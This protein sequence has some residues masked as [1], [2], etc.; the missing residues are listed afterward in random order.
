MPILTRNGQPLYG[1]NQGKVLDLQYS[2][3]AGLRFDGVNDYVQ[4]PLNIDIAN[5]HSFSFWYK[6][7]L[8]GGN[9][10][11]ISTYKGISTLVNGGFVIAPLNSF[12]GFKLFFVIYTTILGVDNCGIYTTTALP[13]SLMH[14]TVVKNTQ[15]RANWKIY[16]DGIEVSV[17]PFGS[18]NVAS[19]VMTGNPMVIGAQLQPTPQFLLNGE[20]YDLKSFNKALTLTEIDY[21]YKTKNT[22]I[23]PTA[24]GNLVA[25]YTFNQKQGLTLLDSSGNG[26]NGTLINFT[27]TTPSVGN[28]WVDDLGNP[29]LV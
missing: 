7:S 12:G 8:Y 15:T 20:L 27:N 11:I 6:P 3:G 1:G 2:V 16:I 17:T 5:D 13:N 10:R 21:M 4:T 19:G 14:V 18:T 23:P 22:R 29:F 9:Q 26:L 24:V 28:A 25:N